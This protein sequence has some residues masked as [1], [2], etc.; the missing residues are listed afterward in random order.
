MPSRTDVRVCSLLHLHLAAAATKGDIRAAR[1]AA[2]G[3]WSNPR[4]RPAWCH[5]AEFEP[6]RV[7]W[8]AIMRPAKAT[9]PSLG[10]APLAPHPETEVSDDNKQ[11][12]L[13]R[14]R[15][16]QLVFSIHQ[17]AKAF[18][19]GVEDVP[20]PANLG[21]LSPDVRRELWAGQALDDSALAKWRASTVV[22]SSMEMQ[23][24][25]GGS[26][27]GQGRY[28]NLPRARTGCRPCSMTGGARS[29]ASTSPSPFIFHPTD[30]N[31]LS[32]PAMCAESHT[33][34]NQLV[35]PTDDTSELACLY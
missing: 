14:Y 22:R 18:G 28:C 7:G 31:S 24:A 2:S 3:V 4:A 20:V 30:A 5:R 23:A 32:G 10:S 19:R 8:C 35:L 12:F 25:W 1:R 13:S 11:G 27:A 9:T 17:Q 6:A 21:L 34:A 26:L 15:M 29:S 16:H 33:C